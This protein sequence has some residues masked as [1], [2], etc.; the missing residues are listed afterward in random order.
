VR[1][2][3]QHPAEFKTGICAQHIGNGFARF[4]VADQ[5]DTYFMGQL[6][7]PLTI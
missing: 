2:A 3:I 6:K 4:A 7:S 1:R 5:A